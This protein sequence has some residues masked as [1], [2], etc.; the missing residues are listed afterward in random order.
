VG[1]STVSGGPYTVL[2]S[3]LTSTNYVDTTALN[4][5]TYYYTVSGTG[6]AGNSPNAVAVLAKPVALPAAP[7]GVTATTGTLQVSLTWTA[8][9]GAATYNV[10]RSTVS[11]G[12]Y[13]VLA[14]GLIGTS[15][16]DNSVLHG[17]TYYFAVTAVN[18]SGTSPNSAQVQV[19]A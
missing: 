1:R 9:T 7:A 15:Y 18:P 2:K 12:P 11:G 4:G 5:T 17:T 13:T 14:S 10:L 8:S 3:G 16:T 19:T 6:I